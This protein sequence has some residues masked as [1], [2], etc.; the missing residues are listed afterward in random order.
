[1]TFI[2]LIAAIAFA[3]SPAPVGVQ[4]DPAA[5]AEHQ[6]HQAQQPPTTR[7]QLPTEASSKPGMAEMRGKMSADCHCCCCEAMMGKHD[8]SKEAPASAEEHEHEKR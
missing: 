2:P 8:A 7:T 5:H 6:Q 1:M 4:A 3:A